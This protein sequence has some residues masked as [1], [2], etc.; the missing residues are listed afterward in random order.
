MDSPPLSSRH[1]NLLGESFSAYPYYGAIHS[2]TRMS[3]KDYRVSLFREK[4][5]DR[6]KCPKCGTWYWTLGEHLT[7]GET[8]CREYSFIG[9]PPTAK[10]FTLR[11]MREAFLSFLEKKGHKRIGRY[12]IVARWRD[13]VFFTQASIYPFQ[14]WVV[15]GVE[16]PPANP[17][18]I[19]Q[20][21]VRFNDIHNVGRTGQH[22]T[23]FEMMAHH[24]FN[25]PNK[26]VYFKDR[27]VKLCHEF[28]TSRLKVDARELTYKEAW[29]SGGGNSG[30]CFEVIL[31]G[32][33]AATLV[34]MV[35]KE[36]EGKPVPM[37]IQV[38]D[39]GYG[40]ERL[41]WISQ[42]T[43]SAYEAIFGEVL[44]SLK[45]S[46]GA[47][48][49][50]KILQE[51]SRVAGL[52]KVET[53]RDIREIRLEVAKRIGIA[54]QDLLKA[55]VPLEN[56]YVLCDHTRALMFLLADGVVPSNVREGYFARLLIRRAIRS[57]EALH[58]NMNLEDIV[59]MQLDQ[60]KADF[61]EL[62]E[63]RASMNRIVHLE[64]GRYTETLRKGMAVVSRLEEK[65][66]AEG[67]KIGIEQLIELYDSHGLN[68]EMVSEFAKEKVEIP[69]DFYGRV[70]ARHEKPEV[71]EEI[72]RELPTDLPATKLR[73]Y[74]DEEK[75][76]F[77]AKVLA[78]R[79]N[80]VVLDQT[81]FYP[82]GGGQEADHG[83]IGWDRVVDV[84]RSGPSILHFIDGKLKLKKGRRVECEVDWVRRV[85][86]MRNHTATHLVLAVSR[87]VLGKHVWQAGA[88]KSESEGRLDIT[89]FDNLK[90]EEKERIERRVNEIILADIPLKKSFIPR[91]EA[92]RKFGFRLYQGGAV[93]GEMVRVVQIPEL[94][95]EACGGTHCE[96]TGQVGPFKILR[97]KRIQDGVLRLEYAAGRP[98][99]DEILKE[100]AI[101]AEM[102]E[103]LGTTIE[104]MSESVKRL[105]SDRKELRKEVDRLK[106]EKMTILAQGAGVKSAAP[107]GIEAGGVWVFT[108]IVPGG[109]NELVAL[110]RELLGG[111]KAVAIL[112]A[113]GLTA[114]IAVGRSEG[115]N[116]D[117][118]EIIGEGAALIGGKGGG[119]PDFA[120]GGGPDLAGLKAAI[121][122]MKEAALS[123]LRAG[124]T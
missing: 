7:C 12:P 3:D 63:S 100:S 90:P 102:A 16:K 114:S 51:Y 99:V 80:I 105:T 108:H 15:S 54:Y 38:V 115:V 101:R 56:L 49:D 10:R 59:A 112:G 96:R 13:D 120:Q 98:A 104:Q 1:Y 89:H 27:T 24:A 81:Y 94:D 76:E 36:V 62:E 124:A 106:R 29:W 71:E 47:S 6:R 72:K 78:V 37:D 82:E 57:I 116:L 107:Q 33:E 43:P 52:T 21:C 119:K 40:L 117:C 48:I 22:F 8:P 64:D 67:G 45:E 103:I 113:E 17:L 109:M 110:A 55:V 26:K 61:P 5:F 93:P 122:K 18:A 4:G 118:R 91:E 77:T 14:P 97:T 85:N 9:N 87:E 92:E 79:D 41:A 86:L 123:K 34:F 74:E 28:M 75:R 68:P 39:T 31:G 84:Q 70:A 121:E 23:M 32:A 88:H 95:V 35:N 25:Y 53:A 66:K 11:E 46:S 30:P 42:G 69:D 50:E 65:L 20:P 58:L 44:S 73:V 111:G 83:T 60:F 2:R 19:S